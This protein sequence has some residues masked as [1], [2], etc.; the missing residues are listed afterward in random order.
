MG[1]LGWDTQIMHDKLQPKWNQS[2]HNDATQ[3]HHAS[4]T[5]HTRGRMGT[6]LDL[7][8]YTWHLLQLCNTKATTN[9]QHWCLHEHTF[10]TWE[11]AWGPHAM[12]PCTG[13]VQL[14][15]ALRHCCQWYICQCLQELAAQLRALPFSGLH[16][17]RARRLSSHRLHS[18]RLCV[19]RAAIERG[20][21]V[22]RLHITRNNAR[23]HVLANIY[24]FRRH[25]K[26]F[27]RNITHLITYDYFRSHSKTFE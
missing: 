8:S 3:M 14:G 11:C 23:I 18:H 17:Q 1:G 7:M 27:R 4:Q 5:G 24:Q 9:T 13:N 16:A 15:V 6:K 19:V 20:W 21:R 22:Q 10:T 2:Q 12:T 26:T 25:S